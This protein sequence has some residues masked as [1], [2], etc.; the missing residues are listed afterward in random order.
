MCGGTSDSE[1][2]WPGREAEDVDDSGDD[3]R[4][5]S[6]VRINAGTVRSDHDFVAAVGDYITADL[7]SMRRGDDG[8]L[9]ARMGCRAHA[10]GGA[11]KNGSVNG[12]WNAGNA[13]G[14]IVFTRRCR[15]RSHRENNTRL[16]RIMT[17]SP[18]IWEIK[19]RLNRYTTAQWAA[20]RGRRIRKCME[21]SQIDYAFFFVLAHWYD[22]DDID[23]SELGSH[24]LVRPWGC[25]GHR[26]ATFT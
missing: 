2:K 20:S 1:C 18:C 15:L 5:A 12:C 14:A 24:V 19:M 4:C 9:A 10:A 17:S 11:T 16:V 23:R 13:R 7:L 6:N 8:P 22:D 21:R 26:R 25:R 3:S